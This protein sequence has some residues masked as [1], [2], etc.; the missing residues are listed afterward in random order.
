MVD[1]QVSLVCLLR[2]QVWG[3]ILDKV[4]LCNP[5][6]TRRG[7]D[8]AECLANKAFLEL[9]RVL[10]DTHHRWDQDQGVPALQRG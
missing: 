10:E 2:H 5:E 9:P 7:K 1:R 8:K 6:C 3:V 4:L